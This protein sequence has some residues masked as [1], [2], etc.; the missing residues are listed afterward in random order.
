MCNMPSSSDERSKRFRPSRYLQLRGVFV[1]DGVE[2]DSLGYKL[3]KGK[4]Q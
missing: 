3:C 2:F 4:K 1:D